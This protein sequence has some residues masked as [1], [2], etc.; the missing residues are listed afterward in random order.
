M[1]THFLFL[2]GQESGV[3]ISLSVHISPW[4]QGSIALRRDM[5]IEPVGCHKHLLKRSHWILEISYDA[6]Y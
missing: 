3:G 1:T 5:Y 4:Y 2:E 6:T